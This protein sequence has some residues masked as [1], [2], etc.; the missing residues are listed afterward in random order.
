MNA[1]NGSFVELHIIQPIPFST[2]NR[3]DTNSVKTV[4]WGGRTRTRVSSQSWKRAMRLHLQQEL[5]ESALRT[6]RLV[7]CVAGRLREA[8][9]WSPELAVRAARHIAVASSVGAEVPKPSK[10]DSAQKSEWSTAA[11]IYVPDLAIGELADLAVKYEAEI[12]AAKELPAKP[13]AK[14]S[15]VPTREVDDILRSRNGVISLFGRML[16]QVDDAKVDGAVQVAHAFTT[17]ETNVEIDYFSAVD[18]VSETWRDATGSAHMGH[19]EHSAGVL[20]RYVV[21]DVRELH[22]N[23]GEQPYDTRALASALL[24]AA[25]FS[26]PQAK[27]RSTAPHT[28]PHLAHITVRQDRPLSYSAAFEQPV[29]PDRGGGHAEPSVAA[30]NAYAAAAERL[31]GGNG[32]V[33]AAHAT[34]SKIDVSALGTAADSFEALIG[35]ALEAALPESPA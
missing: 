33:H 7:E 12:A 18:D 22:H 35:G 5:G 10:G 32:L 24:R 20:Y 25:L 17:H 14:D 9:S 6:R 3:D 21:L 26:L 16:A 31:L 13:Q 8:H 11:M 19:A 1:S 30:L 29:S 28:I 27:K 23:L 2:L 15:A 4:E 34:F